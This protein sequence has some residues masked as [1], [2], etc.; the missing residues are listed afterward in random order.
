M[1]HHK[2]RTTALDTKLSNR[3]QVS[4]P[5][6]FAG[7]LVLD[8]GLPETLI[9]IVAFPHHAGGGQFDEGLSKNKKHPFIDS[10]H[11]GW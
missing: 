9:R 2:Q 11:K 7:L 10:G 1:R 4:Y 5:M 3:I 8:K 6:H